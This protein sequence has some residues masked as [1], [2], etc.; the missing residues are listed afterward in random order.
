MTLHI[1]L[2][3][4]K[5]LSVEIY[6]QIRDAIVN[7]V[8]RP[9]DRIPASRELA[10]TLSVSRMTVTIAYER[11]GAEGFLVSRVGDGTFIS[12]QATGSIA[13]SRTRRVD[14]VLQPRQVWQTI[15]SPGAF[16]P[17]ARFDFRTGIPDAALFPHSAWQRSVMRTLRATRSEAA[18]YGDPAGHPRLRESIARHLGISRGVTILGEDVIVT[19]GTQQAIDVIA[20][21]LL[22]PG[23]RVAVEDPGYWPPRRLFESL[24]ARV[25]GVPVDGE[26]LVVEAMPRHVRAVYV[27]PSHQY[28]LGV[29][30]TLARRQALLEWAGRQDAAILEDDYDSEFRFGDRPLDP[31][32]TL[33][34]AGRVIYIGS[35]SKTL[36]PGLRLGFIVAPR[37]LRDAVR[38]AKFLSDWHSPSLLQATLARFIDDGEFARHVR[39]VHAVYRE[40][41]EMIAHVLARDCANDL[42]P[43]PSSTGLHL[44]VLARTATVAG[45]DA[46]ARRALAAGVAVQTLSFCAVRPETSRAGFA[47]GYGAIATKDINAGLRL[48]RTCLRSARRRDLS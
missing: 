38:R 9:G 25:V 8:L 23:D 15:P 19:S 40:R 36:S 11:L 21:V 29:A 28:P 14:G 27:T 3:G 24:G 44:T 17:A 46:V 18:T 12:P 48:L 37:S 10:S 16:A 4:R 47:L 1:S 13:G 43:I 5:D 6:R 30:M 31:L 32:R 39:R 2:V 45:M 41:R 22:S 35:F 26:G 42:E 33:D 34:V 20:R 7:R